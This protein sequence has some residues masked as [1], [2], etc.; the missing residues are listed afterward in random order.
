MVLGF[1][2]V[3]LKISHD[4]SINGTYVYEIKINLI[5]IA[6]SSRFSIRSET[7][8]ITDVKRGDKWNFECSVDGSIIYSFFIVKGEWNE[9]NFSQIDV[10]QI[11]VNVLSFFF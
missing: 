9:K 5:F 2:V 10:L 7:S 11:L 6:E 4:W 1:V 3:R 8:K